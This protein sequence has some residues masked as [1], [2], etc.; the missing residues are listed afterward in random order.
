MKVGIVSAAAIATSRRLDA[1]FY[2]DPTASVDRQI[3]VARARLAQYTRALPRLEAERERI[4][5]E[6]AGALVEVPDG[7]NS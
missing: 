4:L 7:R 1:E 3:E 2:L 5:A 6:H